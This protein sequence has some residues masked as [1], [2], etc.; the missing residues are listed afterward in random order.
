MLLPSFVGTP[1]MH[2]VPRIDQVTAYHKLPLGE[3][4]PHMSLVLL[5]EAGQDIEEVRELLAA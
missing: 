5:D 2:K 1:K 4:S 3:L